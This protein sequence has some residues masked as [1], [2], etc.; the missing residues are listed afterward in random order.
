MTTGRQ[1][2]IAQAAL[3][4]GVVTVLFLKELPGLLRE[5]RIYRMSGGL[6]AHRRYP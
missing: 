3:L 6:R 4:G 2:L 5:L 1:V